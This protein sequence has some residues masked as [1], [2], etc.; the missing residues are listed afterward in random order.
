MSIKKKIVW[1]IIIV[2]IV[3]I[4][5]IAFNPALSAAFMEGY[6]EARQH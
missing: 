6:N 5:L 3:I 4:A 1:G 2:V